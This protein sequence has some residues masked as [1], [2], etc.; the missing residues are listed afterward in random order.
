MVE[1]GLVGAF[2][3]AVEVA[4]EVGLLARPATTL[5]L[6]RKRGRGKFEEVVDQYFG[7]NLFLDI[8][9]RRCDDKVGPL[10]LIL[11]PP[12]QLRV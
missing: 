7:F 1:V 12:D 11:A 2:G 6:P 10:L 9:R 3:E 4:E 8:E 5:A